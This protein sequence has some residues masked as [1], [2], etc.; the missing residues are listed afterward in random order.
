VKRVKNGKGCVLLL[1]ALVS[2]AGIA[3]EWIWVAVHA[4][5]T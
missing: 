3:A 4:H 5:L 1:L 2:L